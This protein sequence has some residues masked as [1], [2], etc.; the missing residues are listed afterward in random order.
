MKLKPLSLALSLLMATSVLAGPIFD[1]STADMTQD[2][3]KNAGKKGEVSVTKAKSDTGA[4]NVVISDGKEKAEFLDLQE[5][6]DLKVEKD[7]NGKIKNFSIDQDKI[8]ELFKTS[9][10]L[11]VGTMM[12]FERNGKLAFVSENQRFYFI[13]ELYDMYNGMRKIK[14]PDDIK[15]VAFG[16]LRHRIALR[17]TAAADGVTTDIIINHLLNAIHTP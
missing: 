4:T 8:Q 17:Y 6:F 3:L 13:G 14:T 11:K 15:N 7:K 16:V 12:A 2:E 1:G 10:P 5:Y 9:A